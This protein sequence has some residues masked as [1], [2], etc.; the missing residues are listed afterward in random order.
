M[1]AGPA[2]P[3]LGGRILGIT[4]IYGHLPSAHRRNRTECL[5]DGQIGGISGVSPNEGWGRVHADWRAQ[6]WFG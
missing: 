3:G 6:V 1:A 5:F 2:S 4:M